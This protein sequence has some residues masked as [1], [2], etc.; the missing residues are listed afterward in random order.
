[1][2]HQIYAIYNA[3]ASVL[4]ELRYLAQKLSGG[5]SC[6]LCNI[7][8]GLN[9]WGKAQW[10]AGS[11]THAPIVWLH[12]D[13]QSEAL[14]VF[15]KGQLPAV[16]VR[17]DESYVEAINAEELAACQGNYLAFE[18][19]LSQRLRELDLDNKLSKVHSSPS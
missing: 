17:C 9:P 5:A 14:A 7:T 11:S 12:S 16:V 18:R 6:S 15:T 4:G 1:M 19:L 2:T 10:R 13:E 3:E 8:H